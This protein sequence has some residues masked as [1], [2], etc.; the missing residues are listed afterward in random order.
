VTS[1]R[2][3]PKEELRSDAQGNILPPGR[4]AT[5]DLEQ[6]IVSASQLVA[7]RFTTILTGHGAPALASL[8][9]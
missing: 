4:A 9:G 2:H 1:R 3:E 8:S 5:L 6:A 7:R